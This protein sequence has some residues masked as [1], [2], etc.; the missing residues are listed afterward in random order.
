[1]GSFGTGVSWVYVSIHDYGHAG[2]FAAGALTALFCAFWS[3]FPALAAF[4]TVLFRAN[5]SVLGLPLIWVLVE[6]FRGVLLLNG[7]PWLLASY[8]QLNTPLAGYIPLVGAY[9]TSFLLALSATLIVGML[10]RP[11]TWRWQSGA[12]IAIWLIGGLLQTITWTQPIG[13]PLSVALVQGNIPQD[14]KWLPE[15]QLKTMTMYKDMTAQH[16][17][18]DII[19]WPE[20]AIPAYLSEVEGF[21]LAPLQAEAVQHHSDLIVSLPVEGKGRFEMYNSVLTL[22]RHQGIFSKNHL[23]PFG[24][25]MPWQPLSG[26]ILNKLDIR[27]GDFTPGGDAQP[28]LKAGGYPFITSICYEDAFGDAN[29]V[30]LPEAAYLVNVTN[31]AWF[32]NSIEPHQHLQMA[33]MR[34]IETG[35]FMLRATNTGVTAVIAP[36]GSLSAK[37]EP[38]TTTVLTSSITPMGG[39]T[40]YSSIGDLPVVL[41]LLSIFMIWMVYTF[42]QYQSKHK[43]ENL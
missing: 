34:A 11:H 4:L 13:K 15:N 20:S 38:F 7:F 36:D 27:L 8:S 40:P 37:A 18:T 25:Y 17:G 5:K 6:Y 9:G 19:V 30:G 26:Y 31:D 29:I 32:G 39:R 2:I 28:L 43:G 35:R 14:Q 16:W 41:L 21:Y 22:G 33:Q 1:L 42:R 12:L 3:L 10:P 24:E 23:L